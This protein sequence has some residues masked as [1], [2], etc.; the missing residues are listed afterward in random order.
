MTIIFW[1]IL[2]LILFLAL[3]KFYNHLVIDFSPNKK[4]IKK[5]KEDNERFTE[6]INRW[7]KICVSFFRK[8]IKFIIKW[9]IPTGVVLFFVYLLL[10]GEINKEGISKKYMCVQE[11][12]KD[13]KILINVKPWFGLK[14]SYSNIEIENLPKDLS[15]MGDDAF[16]HE[17]AEVFFIPEQKVYKTLF[18]KFI[19]EGYVTESNPY[20]DPN[21]P[22][23]DVPQ[24][25]TKFKPDRLILRM[26]EKK[27]PLWDID[28]F[29]NP[30]KQ[31]DFE[32]CI[33]KPRPID[34]LKL[35]K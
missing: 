28:M 2:G 3:L 11:G 29:D 15:K 23:V 30:D 7:F 17:W 22:L 8:I 35:I 14:K 1:I 10:G 12:N 34:K 9:V 20:Y 5:A 13:N 19:E 33:K 26:S 24:V 18:F 32:V 4:R 27:S 6:V 16:D 31:I 25:I 21:V